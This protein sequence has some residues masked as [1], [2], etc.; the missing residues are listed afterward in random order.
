VCAIYVLIQVVGSLFEGMRECVS[1]RCMYVCMYVCGL[2]F[3]CADGGVF[4]ER[5]VARPARGGVQ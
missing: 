3:G 5:G 1:E 4:D 2:S